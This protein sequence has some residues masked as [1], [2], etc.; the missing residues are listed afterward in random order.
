MERSLAKQTFLVQLSC[1][2]YGYL[3]T[4]KAER[5]SHYSAYITSGSV[6]HEGGDILVRKSV[7]EIGDMWYKKRMIPE[8]AK[9]LNPAFDVTPHE[10]ISAIITEKEI[11]YP[12]F[13]ELSK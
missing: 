11:V 3:P 9:T 7:D 6:G 10:L 5:G 4:E 1:G 8:S 13:T 2:S 12:P